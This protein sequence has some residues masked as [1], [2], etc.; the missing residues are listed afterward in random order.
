MTSTALPFSVDGVPANGD[1]VEVAE[2]AQP[3]SLGDSWTFG[4]DFSQIGSLPVSANTVFGSSTTNPDD[5][6]AYYAALINRGENAGN[7]GSNGVNDHSATAQNIDP[8]AQSGTFYEPQ[9]GT[10]DTNRVVWRSSTMN[11]VAQNNVDNWRLQ[12]W[13]KADGKAVTLG[14]AKDLNGRDD[15][16]PTYGEVVPT[17]NQR[18]AY[19]AANVFKNNVWQESILQYPLDVAGQSA[20]ST[21]R[22]RIVAAGNF[23]AAVDDGVIFA[24]DATQNNDFR[25]YAA[26][27]RA[28][29][30]ATGDRDQSGAPAQSSNSGTQ[31]AAPTT[32]FTVHSA[33]NAWGIAGV[34]AHGTYRAVAFSDGTQQSGNYIGLWADD[35]KTNLGWIHVK[36]ASVVASMNNDWIVWGSGSQADNA[37]MYAFNWQR[38]E[39]EYLGAVQ[40][41]SR[42]TIASDSNTVMVPKFDGTTKA[43]TF[44]V[45]TLQ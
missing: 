42:P 43:V 18:N 44:T 25:A 4:G 1:V 9:D 28:T 36:S 29:D 15:T 35:F 39:V 37:G 16:P 13:N 11:T 17:F 19:F 31:P 14:T 26:L 27:K 33:N 45:G 40:G 41:Y 5:L 38:S 6:R 8:D 30:T 10:G 21:S 3:A 34:W 7:A 20:E 12:T 23:P 22:S 24:T 32:I 2:G